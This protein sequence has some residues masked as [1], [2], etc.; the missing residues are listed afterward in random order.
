MLFHL[1]ST[2][3]H[4][5]SCDPRK[6]PIKVMGKMVFL[7]HTFLLHISIS[8]AIQLEQQC[9]ALHTGLLTPRLHSVA[10]SYI[11]YLEDPHIHL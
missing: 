4:I 1:Q 9:K 3:I 8:V 6:N 10:C 7:L 5:I 2:F 11:C